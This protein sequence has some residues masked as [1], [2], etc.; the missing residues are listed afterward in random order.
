MASTSSKSW[1]DVAS[2]YLEDVEATPHHDLEYI[3]ATSN[4]DL[5]DVEAKLNHDPQV[6]LPEISTLIYGDLNSFNNL[7]LGYEHLASP[8]STTHPPSLATPPPSQHYDLPP[9][10]SS[11]TY[12]TQ[13]LESPAG[14]SPQTPGLTPL[15]LSEPPQALIHDSW[16]NLSAG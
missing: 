8:E 16:T 6:L 10:F 1:F 15:S 14:I 2:I 7:P 5:E 4:Q 13:D 11:V 3:E 9:T 12:Y